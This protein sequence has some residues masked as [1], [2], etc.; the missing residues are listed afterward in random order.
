MCFKQNVP[1]SGRDVIKVIAIIH[2]GIIGFYFA[3]LVTIRN[4][5]WTFMATRYAGSLLLGLL[6]YVW[7]KRK[8]LS[9]SYYLGFQ[10]GKYK[11]FY[12]I[13]IA[14][15]SAIAYPILLNLLSI[16]KHVPIRILEPDV[17]IWLYI[18]LYPLS[19]GGLAGVLLVPLSEEIF[20]RGFLYG[21]IRKNISILPGLLIQ[22][23]IFSVLHLELIY[24]KSVDMLIVTFIFG[25]VLG[26]FYEY[27]DSIYPSVV[28]HSIVNYMVF[29][30]SVY[31]I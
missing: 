19:I 12:P 7:I 29:I 3:F 27:T 31:P 9:P 25:L 13:S 17:P 30:L 16:T 4:S 11:L 24:S 26:I 10:K 20:F 18:M 28:C 14:I 2:T 5:E 21:Y 8:Y 22:S 23:L 1:W 6:P 15:V